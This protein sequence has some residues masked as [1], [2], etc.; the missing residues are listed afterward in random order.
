MSPKGSI[1]TVMSS[2][3]SAKADW[4]YH[5][6]C[7]GEHLSVT[8]SA[9]AHERR[10]GGDQAGQDGEREGVLQAAVERPG[11]QVREERAADERRVVARRQRVQHVRADEALDRV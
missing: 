11:D 4:P 3:R 8:V 6:T 10:R 5:S 9:P 2:P 7:M 1:A